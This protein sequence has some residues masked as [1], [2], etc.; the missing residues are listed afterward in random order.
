MSNSKWRKAFALLS[1]LDP[2]TRATWK[3]I[4]SD[5][6]FAWDVPGADDLMDCGL[7]DGRFQAEEYRWIQW[8][9]FPAKT[10]DGVSV[11]AQLEIVRSALEQAGQFAFRLDSSG[12][13]LFGYRP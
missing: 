8:I 12:L 4:D 10:P 13:R 9:H 1:G 6:V 11:A 5:Q 3:F 2:G 7:K